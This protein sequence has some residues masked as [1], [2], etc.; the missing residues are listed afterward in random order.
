MIEGLFRLYLLALPIVT[1]WAIGQGWRGDRPEL[2]RSAGVVL[3]HAG[4]M[5]LLALAWPPIAGQGYPFLLIAASLVIALRLICMVPALRGNAVL[6][7]SVMGGI[8]A[9]LLYGVHTFARGPSPA[10][11]WAFF[12]AMFTM[13]WVNLIIL[14]GWTHERAVGRI[15][16]ACLSTA[17][18]LVRGAFARGVAR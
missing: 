14:L 3:A 4:L 7:G 10:A 13:G 16:G 11:D 5:Q 9:S 1:L 2:S 18:G 6:G 17:A 12:F 8:L 15:A